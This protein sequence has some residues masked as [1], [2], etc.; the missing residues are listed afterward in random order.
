MSTDERDLVSSTQDEESPTLTTTDEDA[1]ESPEVETESEDK[2]VEAPEV[3]EA[4]KGE[5][6]NPPK[7]KV[8]PPPSDDEDADNIGNRRD[9]NEA[10]PSD[11]YEYDEELDNIGNLINPPEV[12]RDSQDPQKGGRGRRR[13]PLAEDDPFHQ[14]GT[15]V[16]Y[17]GSSV[18]GVRDPNQVQTSGLA[19]DD[20][21][22]Q[23]G[24]APSSWGNTRSNQQGPNR[25]NR[26]RRY[27]ECRKCGVKIEKKRSHERQRRVRCPM[28]GRDMKEYRS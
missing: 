5:P 6:G 26:P 22:W 8:A 16:E 27:L 18:D 25:A 28:C 7:E 13:K 1:L 24:T 10:A 11:P 23:F 15:P 9:P 14:F 17:W 21:F 20:P 19:P 3:E 4:S 12:K 2:D